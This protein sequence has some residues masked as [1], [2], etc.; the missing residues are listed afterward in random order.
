LKTKDTE[1]AAVKLPKCLE[2]PHITCD[3]STNRN[4]VQ[5]RSSSDSRD[6]HSSTHDTRE[7]SSQMR[8]QMV[9]IKGTPS[10]AS[11]LQT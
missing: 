3:K 9:I 5:H 7:G 4:R 8:I 11:L 2:G 10:P 1:F 6:G